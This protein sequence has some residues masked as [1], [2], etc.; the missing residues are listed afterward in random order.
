MEDV[1]NVVGYEGLYIITANGCLFN[2]KTNRMVA[3]HTNK[4]NNYVQT[5]LV[6][7]NGMA[8]YH[9]VHRLV[10]EAFIPNPN[11]LPEVNHK[12]GIKFDNRVENLEWVNRS[13]NMLH[14]WRELHRSHGK[15]VIGVSID[16]ENDVIEFTSIKQAGEY[17]NVHNSAI[18]RALRKGTISAGRRW[19]YKSEYNMED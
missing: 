9:F 12:N 7:N 13:E 10:A 5:R 11:N 1:K 3:K 17:C 8:T 16:N 4:E 18:S 19:Y 15:R 14:C 2:I 6:D